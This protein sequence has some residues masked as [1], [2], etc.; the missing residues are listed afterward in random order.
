[1]AGPGLLLAGG[2]IM[3][4]QAITISIDRQTLYLT[5]PRGGVK[6]YLVS[7]AKNG[8]GELMGSGCTPTG[9]HI[10][11]E[12][13][14]AGCEPNTVFVGRRATGELY[15][16]T[17]SRSDPVC[18]WILTRILW[19][20]GREPGKNQGGELDSYRRYIYIHGAP[21]EVAMGRPGSIGCIRM[22]NEDIIELFD[23]VDVGTGVTINP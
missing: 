5:D 22:R 4:S 6:E 3:A 13:I 18:N 11:A 8:P 19:L 17:T 7:T 21:P 20:S 9:R 16:P 15:D 2:K 1:M 12:K 10:I 23:L 14:G